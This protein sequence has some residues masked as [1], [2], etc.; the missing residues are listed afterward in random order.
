MEPPAAHRVFIA[1]GSNVGDRLAHFEEAA[2]RLALA[3]E[4][5]SMRSSAV[6]ETSPIGPVGSTPFL[7]AVLEARTEMPP[8]A[9]LEQMQQVEV[10]LGR[11]VPREGPRTIDLDLLFY[12]DRIIN[13]PGLIVPHPRL[14]ERVFVLKP[15]ADLDGSLRH[16]NLGRTVLQMLSVLD[17]GSGILAVTAPAIPLA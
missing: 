16:P 9:L 2:R 10:A 8:R 5:G 1:F 4:P 15:L 7:N 14:H 3:F 13:E 6:Y 17:A 12:A 11:Q